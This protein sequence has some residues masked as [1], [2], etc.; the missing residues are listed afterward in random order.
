MHTMTIGEKTSNT[1]KGHNN[2]GS[3]VESV[4]TA[5]MFFFPTLPVV[6]IDYWLLDYGQLQMLTTTSHQHPDNKQGRVS[7]PIPSR[8]VMMA[9]TIST[10]PTAP[11]ISALIDTTTLSAPKDDDEWWPIFFSFKIFFFFSFHYN[12]FNSIFVV[13]SI[14]LLNIN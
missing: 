13:V 3:P 8:P 9:T 5:G 2:K 12:N 10:H 4:S 14:S 6:L 7:N 1:S 11:T